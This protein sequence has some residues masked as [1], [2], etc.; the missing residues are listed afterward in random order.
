MADDLT[1]L[2][3][4]RIKELRKNRGYTQDKFSELLGID[5]KH[6][7]RIECG[8]T[9]PS[10]NLIKKISSILKIQISL[11]FAT[12]FTEGKETLLVK[13]NNILQNSDEKLIRIF[14]KILICINN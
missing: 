6:L 3:G 13:I 1:K 10:L 7:S 14:Y 5:P 9:Q 2:I 4:K 11:L 8:K 12:D